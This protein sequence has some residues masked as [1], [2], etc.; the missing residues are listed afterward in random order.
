MEQETA[1]RS[2]TKQLRE[3]AVRTE[4]QVLW[5]DPKSLAI[6]MRTNEL[7]SKGWLKQMLLGLG[8]NERPLVV[9]VLKH[10]YEN[11]LKMR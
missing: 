8:T 10:R 11:P 2:V 3:F 9:Q 1:V 6:N 4:L 7:P 5:V